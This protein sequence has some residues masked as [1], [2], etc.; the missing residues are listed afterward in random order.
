MI[1]KAYGLFWRRDEV[2]WNPGQGKKTVVDEQ[3]RLLGRIGMNLPNRRIADFRMQ[4]GIYILYGNLGPYYAGLT[5]DQTLGKRLK[6]HLDDKHAELWD[7]FSWFGFCTVKKGKD[8]YGLQMLK[9][10][11]TVSMA[12]PH[13]VIKDIE[14]ILV[15]AMAL[16]NVAD[17]NFVHAERWEQ[18]KLS[19]VRKYFLPHLLSGEAST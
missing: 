14:A 18:L 15:K 5:R 2:L 1:I 7:R 17:S 6:D 12:K 4:R 11:A 9:D 8:E 10:M 3:F 13:F 16:R 19:E